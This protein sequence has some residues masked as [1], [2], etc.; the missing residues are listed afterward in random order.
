[1]TPFDHEGH[2][3]LPRRLPR[4]V[5]RSYV[6]SVSILV[7]NAKLQEEHWIT[8]DRRAETEKWS[9]TQIFM[10]ATG[11]MN[12]HNITGIYEIKDEGPQSSAG[13]YYKIC[14]S[15]PLSMSILQ[16][17]FGAKVEVVA[18]NA[19]D[20]APDFRGEGSS[21]P[22]LIYDGATGFHGHTRAGALYYARA[23][24]HTLPTIEA[25]AMSA[26]SVAKL[27]AER[28]DWFER[29]TDSFMGDEL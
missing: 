12:E 2:A 23:L 20:V 14:A 3:P 6:Q 15:Q 17:L 28:L 22:F 18:Q 13:T 24:E 5:L 27:I 10:T 29:K 25:Q 11:H 21:V 9:P 16:K 26:L 4:A 1:M 7:K 19:W 8:E